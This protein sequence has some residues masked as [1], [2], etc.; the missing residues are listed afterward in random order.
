MWDIKRDG[1]WCVLR[2]PCTSCGLDAHP[3]PQP[4]TRLGLGW[5]VS[6][7]VPAVITVPFS[8]DFSLTFLGGP[9]MRGISNVMDGGTHRGVLVPPVS[10]MLIRIRSRA[11]G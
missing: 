11:L 8:V 10:E 3:N 5:V 1:W 7:G 6:A 2:G 4:S 9:E